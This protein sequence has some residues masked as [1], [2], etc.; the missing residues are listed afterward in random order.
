MGGLPPT[1]PAADGEVE[2]YPI[3]VQ[4]LDYGDAPDT[5]VGTGIGNYPTIASDNGPSHVLGVTNAPY[6]G[7]C[8]DADNGTQQNPAADADDTGAASGTTTGTCITANDDEDGVI[9][10][11]NLTQGQGATINVTA[12]TG[13]NACVLNAWIDYNQNGL[14]TEAGEQIA[15]D[16]T[17]A[18][19]TTVPM[20]L[21]VPATASLGQTYAR[22]RCASVGGLSA[23]GVAADGEVEDYP[24]TVQAL[25]Y[26]DAPDTGVGAGSG[27][28]NTI[29]SDNGPN[30]ILGVPNAPYL[31]AC[32]DAD[33][34]TQ[35]NPAADAD[36]SGATSGTAIGTC[37]SSDDEDG[38]VI[39]ATLIQ[40]Q[41]TSIMVNI[42]TGTNACI[43]NAWIDYNQNGVF[44]DAGEQIAT[45][46][47]IAAGTS[48][49][50]TPTIPAAA[51][52]GQSYARFRCASS[53]GLTPTSAAVDGEVE[54]YAVAID[55]PT[56]LDYGDA[57]DSGTGTGANNYNTTAADNGPSHVLGVAN[58]PHLGLCVDSDNGTQQNAGADA[59]DTGVASGLTTGT[60]AVANDDEDGV[61]LPASLIQGQAT[62]IDI[63]VSAGTNACVL[64]AWIDYNANGVFNDAGEQ[65]ATDQIIATGTTVT[66]TP[67]VPLAATP[68]QSYA[69]FR[70]ATVGGLAPT[71]A[72]AD[73]EI[74][75][76]PVT[77]TVPAA[78]LDYGDAI[79][80]A[81]GNGPDNYQTLATDNGPSHLLGVANAPYLGQCVDADDG[82]LQNAIADADDLGVSSAS[83]IGTCAVAN[84]DE[85]GVSLPAQFIRG[86]AITID[87]R[88]SSATNACILNAWIDYNR[89]GDFTDTGEQIA[90]D[91][92]I[93]SGTSASLNLTVPGDAA[94]GQTY[95]RFRCASSG[96]L[97]S[98]GPAAD[99]EVEDYVI[100]L[101]ALDYGDAPD[102]GAGTGPGNYTTT[103]LDN[104]PSH[105]LGTPGAP[106]LGACVDAD[107][108]SAQNTDADADDNQP[109]TGTTVGRCTSNDDEDGVI[110]STPP[111]R[112]QTATITV[113][114]SAASANCQLDG[115]I[116]Y[117]QNG[118]FTDP[119]EQIAN[120]QTVA[121]GTTATLTPA[122]PASALPGPSYAR[123][124]CSS[125]GGLTPMGLANDGEVEDYA[126]TIRT[127]DYGD[128][129]DTGAGTGSG[130]YHTTAADNG[131]SHIL[132]ANLQIGFCIDDDSG[133]AQNATADADDNSTQ[134]TTTLGIC[135]SA[136]DDEEGIAKAPILSDGQIAPNVS[137]NVSNTTGTPATLSCWV[138][139]NGNGV[140]ETPAERGQVTV[141][142][143]TNNLSVTLTLPDVPSSASADTGGT[144]YLRCRL[145]TGS[146]ADSPTGAASDG[147]VEDYPITLNPITGIDYGDAPDSFGTTTANN[148][149]SHI[150]GTGVYLGSCVDAD[151]DG[152]ASTNA[153]GDDNNIGAPVFG[154]CTNGDEDGVA[155]PPGF[156]GGQTADITA[157]ANE[158]CLLTGWI[159][160]NRDGDWNDAN[161]Q[162][163]ADVSLVA[164]INPLTIDVPADVTPGEAHARFRCSS[165]SGLSPTGP[166]SDGEVEDYFPANLVNVF[167]PPSGFKTV[168]P[169]GAPELVWQMVWFKRWQ[170][171]RTTGEN[172]G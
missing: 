170:Y 4:A 12:S 106:F 94:L 30:H 76:Y 128:A 51:T 1:G 42:S 172:H 166:A 156:V 53:G 149:P 152:Q 138:D 160:W 70:C 52:T 45:D 92:T 140:F 93:A 130:N 31:G 63:T 123:F 117:N 39:P 21:T 171:H 96:G 113:A 40:N 18:T 95:A 155:L 157:T 2:D 44:N 77:I 161:E 74:E 23:T 13:T 28:Y 59:D 151:P 3:T 87:V 115:W 112:G 81:A 159:D 158:A 143:G 132:D 121:S 99:G 164:G 67:T 97:G 24:I 11:T 60:C 10:P 72:A 33:N 144:S 101:R 145:A 136:S 163:F 54:D 5:G 6:L 32:V 89:N 102:T 118:D 162:I 36:D 146:G 71:G 83:T 43:L 17:I 26:G 126:L 119:G 73:G 168:N 9:L 141:A 57:P 122:I 104:G 169:A 103:A 109:S 131:P 50:L 148:G 88:A 91:Q 48:T 19:G 134:S 41:A 7:A 22:F 38:V 14:F 150:L 120:D 29:A 147:E 116:D 125:V 129:P 167:D 105:I 98:T 61:S 142:T 135:V 66:L 111:V 153:D 108:G 85:D 62:S 35:Q 127:R 124:R 165:D 37:T 110:F 75:D 78:E 20:A 84:D 139:Y 25:D 133:T 56:L 79:D 68:G 58:A 107:D 16:Q 15:T 137:V 64:N 100:T 34:G 49:T 27:N 69:R 80:S 82:S 47:S 8:V 46:Q 65:M 114:V 90:S 154:N 55:A 86:Q